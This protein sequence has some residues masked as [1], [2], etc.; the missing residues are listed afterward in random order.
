MYNQCMGGAARKQ[1]DDR[2]NRRQSMESETLFDRVKIKE[3]WH[4][5][6]RTK[7]LPGLESYG[8]Y[9]EETRREMEGSGWKW[10]PCPV[11]VDEFGKQ[12]CD[13]LD[14]KEKKDFQA[15]GFWWGSYYE[16]GAGES[17]FGEEEEPGNE[18][19]GEGSAGSGASVKKNYSDAEIAAI[20]FEVDMYLAGEDDDWGENDWMHHEAY[21]EDEEWS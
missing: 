3:V 4:K 6:G 10:G 12:E 21:T 5:D 17:T 8:E 11:K 15:M 16:A 18:D 14:E 2:Q 1:L 13:Y 9:D 19:G 20:E 7:Q